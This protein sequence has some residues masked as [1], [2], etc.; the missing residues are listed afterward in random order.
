MAGTNGTLSVSAYGEE[1]VEPDECKV[2]VK[3]T[4]ERERVEEAQKASAE[5]FD[6]LKKALSDANIEKEIET[7]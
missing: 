1:R 5:T 6:A 2:K 3:I 4:C 7:T